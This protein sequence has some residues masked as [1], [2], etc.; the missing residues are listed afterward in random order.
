[1][2]KLLKVL[3]V[4][5]S[6]QSICNVQLRKTGFGSK[7]GKICSG[8]LFQII[9][10]NNYCQLQ[11]KVVLSIYGELNDKTERCKFC[12]NKVETCLVMWVVLISVIVELVHGKGE[13]LDHVS[14]KIKVLSHFTENNTFHVTRKKWDILLANLGKENSYELLIRPCTFHAVNFILTAI[15]ILYRYW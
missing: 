1:M 4:K 9:L 10:R 7:Y 11:V 8:F 12:V 6:F 5:V 13:W 3:V 14:R 15:F 2:S